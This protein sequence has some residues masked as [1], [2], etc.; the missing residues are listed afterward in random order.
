LEPSF[1]EQF[2]SALSY[3]VSN[4][5]DALDS[6]STGFDKDFAYHYLTNNISYPLSPD[7]R[8]GLSEFWSLAPEEL[9]SKVRRRL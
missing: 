3:G 1:V 6:F 9:K 7:K 8:K 4:I 2:N 5:A